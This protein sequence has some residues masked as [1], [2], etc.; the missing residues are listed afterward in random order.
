[1]NPAAGKDVGGLAV[2]TANWY[3]AMIV[4]AH[5]NR[6]DCNGAG[7][8]SRILDD[9]GFVHLHVHSSYSLREGAMPVAKL[10]KLALADAMP[11]L[12]I[13]DTNNLFGALEFS[14]K[15]AK[16][17]VQPIPGLQITIDFQDGAARA[18]RGAESA[19]RASI[20]LLA[21]D[22]AGYSNLIHIASRAWLDPEPGDPPHVRLLRLDGRTQGLIALTGGPS[23]PL[24]RAFDHDRGELAFARAAALEKLFLGRLYVEIQRHGLASERAIEPRLLDLA[25]RASLPLVATNEVFFAAASDYEAHDALICIAEGTVVSDGARRQ[26]SPEHRFKTRAEMIALFANLPEALRNSV[27]IALRCAHRPLPRKPILPRFAVKGGIEAEAQELR[28]EAAA[29]LAARLAAHGP[30]SG[31]T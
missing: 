17:G 26:L 1:M 12:A 29:G 2:R 30:A 7:D 6:A 16:E 20:V 18:P 24:D 11:A 10:A 19:C 25:Y 5:G 22:A 27:E 9:V 15:L 13:T 14:E 8:P 28:A 4:H 3:E 23:G 21:Q 31:F